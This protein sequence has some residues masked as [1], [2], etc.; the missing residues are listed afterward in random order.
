MDDKTATID[1]LTQANSLRSRVLSFLQ[2]RNMT[3]CHGAVNSWERAE[4]AREQAEHHGPGGLPWDERLR[5]AR[6]ALSCYR[7]VLDWQDAA[8]TINKRVPGAWAE[9]GEKA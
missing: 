1:T 5:A 7:S 3:V 4:M 8:D 9:V 6:R 2:G